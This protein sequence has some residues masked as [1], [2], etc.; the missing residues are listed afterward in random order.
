MTQFN[1][2]DELLAPN[3]DPDQF[4][5]LDLT[6]KLNEKALSRVQTSVTSMKLPRQKRKNN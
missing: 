3:P 5:N 4:K 1:R 6:Q 2:T